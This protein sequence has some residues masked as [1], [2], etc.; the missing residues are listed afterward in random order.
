MA[1]AVTGQGDQD[2]FIQVGSRE[3]CGD[4]SALYQSRAARGIETDLRAQR[5]AR[6]AGYLIQVKQTAEYRLWTWRPRA[7]QL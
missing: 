2:T 7:E 1:E 4:M 6:L 5:P 3:H